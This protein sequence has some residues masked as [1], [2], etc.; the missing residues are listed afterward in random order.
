MMTENLTDVSAKPEKEKL[1]TREELEKIVEQRLLRERKNTE[2]LTKIRDT[3]LLLRKKEAF[4]NLSNAS[5]ADKLEELEKG[6]PDAEEKPTG[7]VMADSKTPP[8]LSDAASAHDGNNADMAEPVFREK[9]TFYDDGERRK[10]EL[11]EFLAR[12]GETKLEQALA[13]T[14]FRLFSRGKRGDIL[15]L[16][17]DYLG[18]LDGLASSPEAKRYR[19]AQR[20]LAS[21]GFSG[22]ASC[23][24]DYGSMLSDNQRRIAKAAGMSYRQYA[25]LLSQIPSKK[26]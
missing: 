19:A 4:K 25:E 8:E 12:Y 20:E 18:F 14:S 1:F 6:V 26:L 13:D 15:S 9:E 22:G 23:A 24:A 11:A 17:E 5:L 2:S 10:M 16:Y 3:L 21:T 7:S